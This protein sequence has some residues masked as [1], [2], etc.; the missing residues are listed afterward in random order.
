MRTCITGTTLCDMA[1]S[2]SCTMAQVAF[3]NFGAYIVDGTG[4]GDGPGTKLG[5]TPEV[6]TIHIA[7]TRGVA[8]ALHDGK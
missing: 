7:C 2:S 5:G 8:L 3:I 4:D 6:I 1:L